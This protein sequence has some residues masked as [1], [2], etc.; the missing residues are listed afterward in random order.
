[1]TVRP[2]ACTRC[3]RFAVTGC[4]HEL[5]REG[6]APVGRWAEVGGRGD[7]PTPPHALTRVRS[8]VCSARP[9][10]Q[11]TLNGSTNVVIKAFR[12]LPHTGLPLEIKSVEMA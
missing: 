4:W 2:P 12:P 10:T 11:A 5:P 3:L 9:S 6:K 7:V 1:M 8:C